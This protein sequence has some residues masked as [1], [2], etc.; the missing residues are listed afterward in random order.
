MAEWLR[1]STATPIRSLALE[2]K[3]ISVGNILGRDQ[4]LTQAEIHARH[5]KHQNQCLE[6]IWYK[7]AKE[8]Q[9]KV[10]TLKFEDVAQIW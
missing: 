3:T 9:T 1:L 10:S 6:N 5:F 4:K 2:S 8:Q 7:S